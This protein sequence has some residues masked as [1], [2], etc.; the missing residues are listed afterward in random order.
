M[1]I[2]FLLSINQIFLALC[3]SNNLLL[4]SEYFQYYVVKRWVL[5]KPSI[6][7]FFFCLFVLAGS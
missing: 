2:I 6:E 5:L 4:Y 3:I 1:V 7:I